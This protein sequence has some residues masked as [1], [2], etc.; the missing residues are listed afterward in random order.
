M[1]RRFSEDGGLWRTQCLRDFPFA[2]ARVEDGPTAWK[3]AYVRAKR[4][5]RGW[6]AGTT[7][8][9]ELKSMRAPTPDD[10]QVRPVTAMLMVG[11]NDVYSANDSVVHRWTRQQQAWSCHLTGKCSALYSGG[12]GA[13]WAQC[14]DGMIRIEANGTVAQELTES[15]PSCAVSLGPVCAWATGATVRWS[16]GSVKAQEAPLVQ[17]LVVEGGWLGVDTGGITHYSLDGVKT[18]HRHPVGYNVRTARALT[19]RVVAVIG[20]HTQFQLYDAKTNSV[21]NAVAPGPVADILYDDGRLVII[22]TSSRVT[23]HPL[24]LAADGALIAGQLAAPLHRIDSGVQHGG[25]NE[26]ALLGRRLV[27]ASKANNVMVCD[28]LDGRSL[29]V[30]PGGSL[31]QRDDNPAN[32]QR[33]G[34]SFVQLWHGG[35]TAAFNAVVKQWRIKD[36]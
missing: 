33:P 22:D 15:A 4:C 14:S 10:G 11:P 7:R 30:L 1:L 31:Q 13:V 28:V 18:L 21:M 6:K 23:V 34:C 35:V 19:H 5:E 8:D 16:S 9:W 24:T 2:A 12:D 26:W 25:I 32:P 3:L 17:L 20:T 36:I 27:G 29:Y